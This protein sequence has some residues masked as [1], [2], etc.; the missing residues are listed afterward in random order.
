MVAINSFTANRA[1]VAQLAQLTARS[2]AEFG[3]AAATVPSVNPAYGDHLVLTRPGRTPRV[4]A[5][6]THLDTV[7]PP[8][9]EQRN[10][11]FWRPEGDRIYGP[12]TLDIKG[13][14]IMIHL[15]MSA[16]REVAPEIFG[17]ITWKIF[18][19]SSEEVLS[20]DFG[21]LCLERLGPQPLA[22]LVFEAEG[23]QDGETSLVT[24][25]KGRATFRLTVEG[26]AA[27]A[28]GKHQR[29]ANAIVQIA[30]T[31]ERIAE[32][33]DYPRDLTF[34]V[35]TVGGGSVTNRVPHHAIAE[36]EMRAFTPDVYESGKRAILALSGQ[37]VV[38][39]ASDGH[40]CHVTI[41]LQHESP[42]WPPNAATD[43][44]FRLWQQTGQEIGHAVHAEQRGGLSDGNLICHAVPTLDGLGPRGDN[45]HCSEQSADGSKQQEYVEASSFVPKAALNAL[46]IRQLVR[47][48]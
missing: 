46:A 40:P 6:I 5:L 28:G 30:H 15:V 7:F 14:T 10:H 36:I 1:G 26:R 23:R 17:E 13:G 45:D 43:R 41:E 29:G 3:F 18:A 48:D 32:L 19:N 21:R 4:V 39:A 42:P 8:E 24:A 2:F 16:L 9:E 33:T 12:G 11:F 25:R 20:H 34:N 22:A 37:S 38:R 47:P 31:I 35:G 27:H 44:L